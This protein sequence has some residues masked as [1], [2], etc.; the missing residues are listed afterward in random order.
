[1]EKPGI[2]LR[3]FSSTLVVFSLRVANCFLRFYSCPFCVEP[4]FGII[5]YPPNS[6]G[7][8]EKAARPDA[9]ELS[10]EAP[11]PSSV[12]SPIITDQSQLSQSMPT[13]ISPIAAGF[14]NDRSD[15][16]SSQTSKK[17]GK[18]R[19]ESMSY[20]APGVVTV[21]DLRPDWFKKHQQLLLARA[22]QQQQRRYASLLASS[23]GAARPPPPEQRRESEEAP[24]LV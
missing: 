24:D 19:R 5:Y 12:L 8:L 18:R 6:P 9:E 22:I 23:S 7:Y 16:P 1:M 2:L 20:K 17:P 14:P 10:L 15:T 21:D 11:Q 3:E 4:H 13:E